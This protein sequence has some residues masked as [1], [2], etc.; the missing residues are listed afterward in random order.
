MLNI[1]LCV[2]YFYVFIGLHFYVFIVSHCVECV[3]F[4]YLNLAHATKL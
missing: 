1:G 4:L 2:F 3:F